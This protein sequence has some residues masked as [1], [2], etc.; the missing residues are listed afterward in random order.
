M[1]R[2]STDVGLL[3]CALSADERQIVDDMKA[4]C[5]LA[6]DADL[7]RTALWDFSEHLDMQV[8]LKKGA[9]DLRPRQ[10]WKNHP[11][12]ANLPGHTFNDHQKKP[13]TPRAALRCGLRSKPDHPWR[14]PC[15]ASKSLP[16][17]PI[18]TTSKP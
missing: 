3:S 4:R 11:T 15:P 9:F 14:Q 18:T 13:T 17:A 12:P 8:D 5:G 10:G 2:R 16:P 6:S 7:V 1:P